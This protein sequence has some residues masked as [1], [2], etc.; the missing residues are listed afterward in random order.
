M[1][2]Q[3]D[4]AAL[5]FEIFGTMVMGGILALAVIF[6]L[7]ALFSPQ[8]LS[9]LFAMRPTP[10]CATG[11]VISDKTSMPSAFEQ[12]ATVATPKDINASAQMFRRTLV[13]TLTCADG[14]YVIETRENP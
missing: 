9:E 8:K 1:K 11:W 6:A 2:Q 14:R 7:A 3:H 13:L 10:P 4:T 12:L 5:I